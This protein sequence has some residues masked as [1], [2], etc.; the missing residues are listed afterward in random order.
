MSV[1]PPPWTA[2]LFGALNQC[3]P[4][5]ASDRRVLL[6][7]QI[8]ILER[9]PDRAVLLNRWY[10]PIGML[11]DYDFT[12]PYEGHPEA[13]IHFELFKLANPLLNDDGYFFEDASAP[14]VSLA[15]LC[16]YREKIID[17]VSPWIDPAQWE[18]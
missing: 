2:A 16:V 18:A 5:Q 9:L 13:H 12:N 10:K 15:C 8:Q 3:T 1:I 11:N 6:P 17:L 7:Y 4:K 14:W